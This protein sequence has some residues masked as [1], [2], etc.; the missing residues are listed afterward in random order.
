[1]ATAPEQV[2]GEEIDFSLADLAGL[3]A[4]EIQEVRS[5]SLPAGVY[6]F[7][8]REAK[9]EETT[10]RDSEKRFVLTC[11]MEV[12]EV[13]AVVDRGVD[14]ESLLGKMHTERFYIVPEKASEG[15]GRIRAFYAD[16]GL[17]NEGAFG[18]VEGEPEGFVDG[19]PGHVFPGKII[20]QGRKD[21]PGTK[22]SRLR[23]EPPKTGKK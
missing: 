17:P 16:I 13:K 21:D 12:G 23:I 22:D 10:N 3:D 11:K 20:K 4:T 9:F 18:G 1:M 14:K 7:I 5:E 6:E 19:F 15:L 2:E 8:G